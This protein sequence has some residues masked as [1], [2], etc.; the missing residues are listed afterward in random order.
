MF[1]FIFLCKNIL[2]DLYINQLNGYTYQSYC[3][4]F[5]SLLKKKWFVLLVQG[6][7]FVLLFVVASFDTLALCV[8]LIIEFLIFY[9]NFCDIKFALKLKYTNRIKR[10]LILYFILLVML[11]VLFLIYLSDKYIALLFAIA[12]IL[13]F[14][15][16]TIV[17]LCVSL[18][19]KFIGFYYINKCK[20]KLNNNSCI[21]KIG[22][23][24][25]YGKTSTKEIL[26]SILSAEFNV[27]STPKSFNT[28]FGIT[29][30]IN[31]QLSSTH[32]VFIAEMGAKKVGEIKYLC[33]LVNVD[34]GIITSVGRQHT[35]T[36]CGI[37]GV[38][39]TKKE[40]VDFL[41][42]KNCVFNLMNHYVF[43]MYKNF[44]G[45]SIG[46]FLIVNKD[47]GLRFSII[48]SHNIYKLIHNN[49]SGVNSLIFKTNCFFEFPKKNNLYAKNIV[50]NSG[51]SSFDVCYSGEWLFRVDFSLMGLHNIINCLLAIAMAYMLGESLENIKLGVVK[52][53]SINARLEKYVTKSGA[54]VFNNGYN[55]NLDSAKFSLAI[56]DIFRDKKKIVVTPGIVETEDDFKYNMDFAKLVASRC[57]EIV[58]VKNKN[59]DAIKAGLKNSG[60]D[61]SRVA[62]YE[63]FLLAKKYIE[64]LGD[65]CV[66]LIE[67]D[68]P[69]NY[70]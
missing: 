22:I 51:G 4:S 29:K 56:L 26:N 19:E 58:V 37:D 41:T 1:L 34:Y 27:L 47:C 8:Y 21:K 39:R 60:F 11:C 36:F 6:F 13:N 53:K 23:T 61:M 31:E 67:N 48:K 33:N 15:M 66:V 65:D 28:P 69:D 10:F 62:F 50:L 30:T 2:V 38:Y 7:L 5:C 20:M 55:S 24:G 14:C 18:V 40:L 57:D 12:P 32:E 59:K 17:W 43:S 68:L 70:T 54:I 63:N 49:L 25:S 52:V 3:V 35:D 16:F 46:V 9:F 42:N 64:N 45:D 44:V